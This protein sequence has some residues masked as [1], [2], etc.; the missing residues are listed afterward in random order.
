M[1]I[2]VII[3]TKNEEKNLP[4]LLK[5]LKRQ[6]FQGFETIIVDN[7]ST[8]K[9]F[10]VAKKYSPLVFK[11]G[12][13]R[14][15]QRNFGL[16]KAK[17]AF[18]LFLDADMKLEKNLLQECLAKI[19]NKSVAAIIIDEVVKK[20]NFF[21]QVKALEKALIAKNELLEAPR[22]F[23]KKQIMQIKGFDTNLIAGEDW[24]LGKR[25]EKFG[26]FERIKSKIINHETSFIRDLKKKYYYAK[27][28]E[29]YAKKYPKNFKSQSGIMRLKILFSK[30]KLIIENPLV[31]FTLLCLKFTQYVA[32]IAARF[33]ARF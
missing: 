29:K 33:N 23:R 22:F 16:K 26:K 8:D 18:V 25:M 32:Y 21:S 24:D 12:Y 14:S 13:E 17:G 6:T 27:S 19:N 10:E 5:S 2:S 9:T 31:F 30:P 3:A 4:I 7:F 20:N 11:S 28:I 1:K 15:S